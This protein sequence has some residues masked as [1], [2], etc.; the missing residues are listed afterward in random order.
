MPR[1][2][3]GHVR[4]INGVATARIRITSDVRESF[5]LPNCK[6]DQEA[7]ERARMLAE[8]AQRLRRAQAGLERSR[9]ALKNIA[10]A[11][12]PRSLG[13]ALDVVEELIGG[14]LDIAS[15]PNVPTFGEI[16][17]DWTSGKLR[18]RYPDHVKAK[19]TADEDVARLER[20]VFPVLKDIPIDRVTLEMCQEVMRRAPADLA[21]PTRRNIAGMMVRVMRM[22][23]FP[24]GVIKQSPIP[25]GFLPKLGKRKAM[26]C[27][28]PDEDA[29][30]IGLHVDSA[31]LSALVGLPIA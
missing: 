24:I 28:Y 5:A 4:W 8:V 12:S 22:A 27:L 16:A 20:Y 18:E 31:L 1:K 29:R 21:V 15:K 26:A 30:L 7:H 2:A 11:S 9:E 17:K 3:T 14:R 13:F 19:R 25:V 10:G 23:A 6:S